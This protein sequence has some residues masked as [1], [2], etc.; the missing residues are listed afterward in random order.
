[1]NKV[2]IYDIK[3]RTAGGFHSW[4]NSNVGLIRK[5]NKDIP[6]ITKIKKEEKE[7]G[8]VEDKRIKPVSIKL[9]WYQ[10]VFNWIVLSLKGRYFEKS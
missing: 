7:V 4:V 5:P 2:E 8:G 6:E 9:K 1:M 10:K 3:K